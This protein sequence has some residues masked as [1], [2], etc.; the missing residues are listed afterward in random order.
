MLVGADTPFTV[1]G[2]DDQAIYGWRGATLDNLAQL[3]RDYPRAHR[4]Q[5][6]AELPLDGAHPALRQR[7]DREEP[8][9]LRQE[10]VERARPRRHAARHACR[11]RRGGSGDGRRA[12]A[13]RALRP[14]ST[15]R[16]LR[17]PLSRQPSGARV[18]DGVARALGSVRD[19]RRHVDL[20]PHRDPRHRRVPARHRERGRRSG[21][22]ARGDGAAARH[23]RDDARAPRARSA[24]RAARACSRRRSSPPSPARCR[25]ASAMASP[26]S[27]R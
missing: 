12:A 15:L 8:E 20:R 2:D 1:V 4:D 19:L 16:R 22:R 21:V 24:R 23:R 11:R 13:R 7:A 18:R 9:A 14:A 10:A 27:A 17:D 3:P 6:R 26:S 25:R 5:A